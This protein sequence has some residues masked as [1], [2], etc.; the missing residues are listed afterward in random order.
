MNLCNEIYDMYNIMETIQLL[1]TVG[2]KGGI[3]NSIVPQKSQINVSSSY[4]IKH[5]AITQELKL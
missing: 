4:R 1:S 2:H 3:L 5:C